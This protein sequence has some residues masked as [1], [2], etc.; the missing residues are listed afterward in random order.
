MVWLEVE[1]LSETET[2]LCN[3]IN[4]NTK[5][6]KRQHKRIILVPPIN[7]ESSNPL[8]LLRDFHYNHTRLQF[9]QTH[10]QE[11]SFAQSHKKETYIIRVEQTN[12]IVFY[13]WYTIIGVR[14]LSLDDFWYLRNSKI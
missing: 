14:N 4:L 5:R 13:I 1:F 9:A 7:R 12:K 3:E 8:A 6:E 11:T 10:K 2:E